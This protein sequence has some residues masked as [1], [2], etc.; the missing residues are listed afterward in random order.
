MATYKVIQDIEAE[1]KILGPLTL[2]QF[3]F[4]L[5]AVFFGYMT[6]IVIAKHVAFL[7]I[8][9][10]PPLIFFGFFALPFGRD[11]PTEIWAL[12][13]LRFYFK[14]RKRIWNQSGVKELVTITVPKKVEH[15]YSDGLSQTEVKSRLET[16]A[17]T[18][19][20]RGWATKHVGTYVNPSNSFTSQDSQRLISLG[21]QPRE[22]PDSDVAASDDILDADNN[23][24][25]RQFDNLINRT[26]QDRRQQLIEQINAASPPKFAQ[27]PPASPPANGWYMQSTANS[28]APA[29]SAQPI[30]QDAALSQQLKQA[31]GPSQSATD[32][33]RT[34]Q[35]AKPTAPVS[36]SVLTTPPP[37]VTAPSDPA[38]ITLASRNDLNVA[39]IAREAEKA[40]RGDSLPNGE[41]VITL[42]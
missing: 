9:F 13:K 16:L 41:V 11:Q 1:D 3:I 24:I 35:T 18:I 37:E 22:V 17:S 8:L 31:A 10:A 2:R 14:P 23:P 5:L 26:S 42:H 30:A 34:L 32:N 40:T 29:Q 27:T 28:P 38:I 7:A 6:F 15:Y 12:A 36:T 4:A 19:D 20:S 33:M 25:A 21:K 39:T